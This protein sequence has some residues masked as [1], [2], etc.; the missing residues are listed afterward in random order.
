MGDDL[1][2]LA[3]TQ[4]VLEGTIE[5]YG[6]TGRRT[7]TQTQRGRRYR[8]QANN[9][10]GPRRMPPRQ[11]QSDRDDLSSR[12][13]REPLAAYRERMS[14]GDPFLQEKVSSLELLCRTESLM[15]WGAG[16]HFERCQSLL[17]STAIAA[18]ISGAG[19]PQPHALL[20]PI[21]VAYELGE[22]T[23][24]PFR[25][26]R[27]SH[28]PFGELSDSGACAA[29]FSSVFVLLESIKTHWHDNPDLDRIE[30]RLPPLQDG[31][32][33][34]EPMRE[35]FVRGM[36]ALF[37]KLVHLGEF[38]VNAPGGLT[39]AFVR[40]TG[41]Y[42][43]LH[44]LWTQAFAGRL[45]EQA[46]R[47]LSPAQKMAFVMG[48][49]DRLGAASPV[50]WLNRDTAELILKQVERLRLDVIWILQEDR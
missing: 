42:E 32:V 10:R 37:Q 7:Q 13:I 38:V 31:D 35:V 2:D 5:T 44:G 34:P 33:I 23:S 19:R 11:L 9:N 39:A 48:L 14:G 41:G 16:R 43:E 24:P 46:Q 49:H 15:A 22:F 50:C 40:E 20:A 47:V 45:E 28:P 6:S 8:A 12:A 26:L 36:T 3:W 25:I 18:V 27:L 29:W 21:R 1:G 4:G 17:R 30:F